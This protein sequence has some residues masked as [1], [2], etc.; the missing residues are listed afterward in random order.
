MI[1]TRFC[2]LEDQ[3]RLGDGLRSIIVIANRWNEHPTLLEA[4]KVVGPKERLL[5][6]SQVGGV[7]SAAAAELNDY[8]GLQSVQ[9]ADVQPIGVPGNKILEDNDEEE[10]EEEEEEE[11]DDHDHDHV[12]ED[13]SKDDI[14]PG[15]VMDPHI[16][17]T[18]SMVTTTMSTSSVRPTQEAAGRKPITTTT[19]ELPP[20]RTKSKKVFLPDPTADASRP[21]WPE[22]TEAPTTAAETSSGTTIKRPAETSSE[23]TVSRPAETSSERTANR[24]AE[25]SSGENPTVD[26]GESGSIAQEIHFDPLMN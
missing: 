9:L 22:D 13:K 3:A 23:R 24:P 6:C 16:S 11:G 1:C 20:T 25:T 14:S 26:S 15:I 21:L 5:L 7:D 2:R 18:A 17:T 4:L 19:T 12:D 10:E 8:G